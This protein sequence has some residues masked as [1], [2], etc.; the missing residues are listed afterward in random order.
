M[1]KKFWLLILEILKEPLIYE[2]VVKREEW[3]GV[4]RT[5]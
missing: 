3:R 5:G 1:L 2:E 4:E